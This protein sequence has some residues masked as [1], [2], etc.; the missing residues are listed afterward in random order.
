MSSDLRI[1]LKGFLQFF[2]GALLSAGIYYLYVYSLEHPIAIE[3]WVENFQELFLLI[4]AV[5][6]GITARR[7]PS[8]AGG[9]WLISGFCTALFIRELDALFD[10]VRHGFWKYVLIAYL[11]VLAVVIA[12]A[13]RETILPGLAHFISSR[14]YMLMLPAVVIILA[15]SRLYGYKLLWMHFDFCSNWGEFKSFSEEATEL[16]GYTLL[17]CSALVYAFSNSG[18]KSLKD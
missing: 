10:L 2:I 6:F 3:S 14:A 13:G 9:L 12:R 8:L 18:R 1:I 11:C 15:Y 4:G 16:L 7:N 5:A 17:M